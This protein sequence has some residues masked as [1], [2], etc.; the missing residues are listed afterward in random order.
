MKISC[1]IPCYNDISYLPAVLN[2]IQNCPSISE[3]ICVDDGSIPPIPE[4]LKKTFKNVR[5]LKQ[6]VNRGKSRAV[7]MALEYV[8][9]ESVLIL[10]ADI[11]SI[12]VQRLEYYIQQ[13]QACHIDLLLFPSTVFYLFNRLSRHNILF[14]GVRLMKKA[15]LAQAYREEHP[16]RYQ[17]EIGINRYFRKHKKVVRYC[18][19][20]YKAVS[21]KEK[22][23]ILHGTISN[24]RMLKDILQY[25]FPE[26]LI[27][28]LSFAHQKLLLKQSD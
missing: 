5:F 7:H 2:E 13:F 1:I 8:T 9:H 6:A 11:Y 19:L 16:D 18:F 12:D 22:L 23:G 21:K 25:K 4:Q 15:D 14:T 10:D 3:I 17:F 26:Y 20:E 27:Q 28:V 24:M